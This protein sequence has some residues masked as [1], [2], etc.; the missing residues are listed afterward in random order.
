[1]S[2]IFQYRKILG[3][4]PDGKE[5]WEVCSLLT[6][7]FMGFALDVFIDKQDPI[8]NEV[9]STINNTFHSILSVV[10]KKMRFVENEPLLYK[11]LKQKASF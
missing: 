9:K 2:F 8:D 3:V 5:K 11:Y 1:M 7:R 4:Q 6:K 10:K